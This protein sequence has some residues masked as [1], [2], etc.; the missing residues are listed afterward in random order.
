MAIFTF[1]YTKVGDTVIRVIPRNNNNECGLGQECT[2]TR[3][4]DELIDV[5]C[6]PIFSSAVF[7]KTNGTAVNGDKSF[8]VPFSKSV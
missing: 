8:I 2:V 7:L 5:S 6:L 3:V 1:R 4:T